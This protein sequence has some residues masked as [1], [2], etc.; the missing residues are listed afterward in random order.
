VKCSLHVGGVQGGGLDKTE[1]VLLSEGLA[2]VCGHSP[3]VPQVRLVTN[4]H[5]DDVGVGVVP[6]LPKP[7]LDVLVCEVLG[8]VV[9]EERAHGPP[10]VGGGDGAVPLLPRRV[11]DL[12]LDGLPVNLE[13]DNGIR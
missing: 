13:Q 4:Q 12:G 6:E 1:V 5:D 10:V 11:P 7:P 3:K 9:D 2:L 8:D